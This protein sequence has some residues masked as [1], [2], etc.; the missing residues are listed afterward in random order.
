MMISAFHH[1]NKGKTIKISSYQQ[2]KQPTAMF[3]EDEAVW[4]CFL[5]R[6]VAMFHVDLISLFTSESHCD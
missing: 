6:Q 4:F 3:N 1:W 2:P 5:M